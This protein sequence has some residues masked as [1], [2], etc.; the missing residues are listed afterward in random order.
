MTFRRNVLP[1]PRK[2]KRKPTVEKVV[3]TQREIYIERGNVG[4]MALSEPIGA[5]STVKE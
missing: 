2:L 4:K 1:L 3:R 5:R